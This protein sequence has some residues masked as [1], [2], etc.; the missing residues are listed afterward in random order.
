ML[1]CVA[2]G[3]ND[4]KHRPGR[5]LAGLA[6]TLERAAAAGWPQTLRLTV[7]IAACAAAAALVIA[8]YR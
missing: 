6:A 4:G 3:L 5:V 8:A 2:N 1:T 7:L